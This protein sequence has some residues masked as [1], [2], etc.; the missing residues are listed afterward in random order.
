[1]LG[2]TCVIYLLFGTYP[3]NWQDPLPPNG[4]VRDRDGTLS[5]PSPGVA[6]A[7]TTWLPDA[8]RTGRLNATVCART[9]ETAQTGPARILTFSRDPYFLNFTLGQEGSALIV[10]LRTGKD[11]TGEIERKIPGVFASRAWRKIQMQVEPGA[12]NVF[13]DGVLRLRQTLEGNPIA[14]FDASYGLLLGNEMSGNRPWL[15][16]L[17]CASAGTPGNEVDLLAAGGA[18][19]PWRVERLA[20]PPQLIPFRDLGAADAVINLF[21]F[22]PLGVLAGILLQPGT[23]TGWVLLWLPAL[24]L[25]LTIEVVQFTLPGRF[26][27]VNDL[28]LNCAGAVLGLAIAARLFQRKVSS[29]TSDNLTEGRDH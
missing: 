8:A 26:P 27:S 21:G 14:W 20:R 19:I 25:S 5:F 18:V 16:D 3:F 10:R 13:V 12:L 28:I 22:V 7:R 24:V 15:G 1:V 23:R 2:A 9:R 6:R 17:R 4:A 11:G 29:R